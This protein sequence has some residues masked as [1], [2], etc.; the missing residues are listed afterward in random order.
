[1][2]IKK[3]TVKGKRGHKVLFV[4]EGNYKPL[5]TSGNVYNDDRDAERAIDLVRQHFL[6]EERSKRRVSSRK[7]TEIDRV[8]TSVKWRREQ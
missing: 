8:H 1:M 2:F 4:S 6:K 7:K 5:F 3:Q